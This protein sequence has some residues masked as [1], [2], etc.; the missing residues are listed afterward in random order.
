MKHRDFFLG[1]LLSVSLVAAGCGHSGFT[2]VKGSVKLDGKA[3]TSGQVTF[4]PVAGKGTAGYAEI[5]SDGSF[6]A[7]IGS[8]KGL[9]PGEYGV[10]V[11][12]YGPMPPATPGAAE[13]IPPL[14]TPPQYADIKTSGIKY[15]VPGGALEIDL[16][17]K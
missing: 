14:I 10:A 8:Q 13:P 1:V 6:T 5:R 7:Q 9:P 12:A 4:K 16:K 15:T 17:S 3:L 11:T 2:S